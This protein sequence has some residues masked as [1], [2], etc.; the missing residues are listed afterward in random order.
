MYYILSA[1]LYNIYLQKSRL[2]QHLQE[3]DKDIRNYLTD[4]SETSLRAA[5]RRTDV[6]KHCLMLEG[7]VQALR[8]ERRATADQLR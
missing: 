7:R 4:G 1:L 5:L 2:L 8:R 6:Y 3:I